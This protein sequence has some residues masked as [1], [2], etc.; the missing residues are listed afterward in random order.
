MECDRKA[1]GVFFKQDEAIRDLTVTG[2]QTCALPISPPSWTKAPS[3][4]AMERRVV[5]AFWLEIIKTEALAPATSSREASGVVSAPM[6]TS[7]A[8]PV[9][10]KAYPL[11]VKSSVMVMSSLTMAS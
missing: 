10:R 1:L 2:V 3:A 6:A 7:S 5:E 9:A 11:T 4:D 8:A